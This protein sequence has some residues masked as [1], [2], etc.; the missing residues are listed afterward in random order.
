M[1]MVG[2]KLIS[3][4]RWRRLFLLL[5]L[6]LL[7]VPATRATHI[8]GGEMELQY[9][10]G[11]TYTL[12][13]NLYFDAINGSP[14]ALDQQ[15]RA[16][17]FAKATNQRMQD[18]MLPLVS[19]TFVNYT[20]PACAR[21]SL[22]TRKL[23]YSRDVTLDASQYT[24]AGGYYAA[25][26]RCC[27]NNGISN[28]T[29]SLTSGQTFYLEFPAVVRNGQPFRDSTPRI[30][31][32]LGDYAC[33]NE[34]FY[35]DFGGQDS[36]GDSLVYSMITPLTAPQGT[37]ALTQAGPYAL[38]NWV[39]GLSEQQQIPGTPT[40]GIDARTGRLTIRPSQV[41]LF[42]FGIRCEEYRQGVKIGET[43]R[44]FQLFV[45]DCTPNTRPSAQVYTGSST[46]AYRPGRDTLRI[47]PGQNPCVRVRFTDTDP[48]SRLTLSVRPVN[49]SGPVPTVAGTA[50]GLVRGAGLADTLQGTVCFSPCLDSKGQVWLL[51]VLVAD[52]GCSL[53]KLDTVRLAFTARPAPNAAPT[54]I[55]SF[56]ATDPAAAVLVKVPLGSVYTAQLRATDA[57]RNPLV[58]S[59][60]PQN[61]D[62]TAA[63]MEFSA[64]NGAGQATGT[65]RWLPTCEAAQLGDEL[66][67]QFQLRETADCPTAP[68]LV[69]VR[70][71][72]GPPVDTVAFSP[73]NIITPNGDDKNDAFTIPSLPPDYC[74]ARF[75]GIKIYSRWGREVFQSA[76]RTFRWGGAG[77]AGTYYYL[78]TYSNGR[79]YK[80]WV[81]VLQ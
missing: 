16:A 75:A 66:T 3:G 6:W 59:A 49:F 80:G 52:N 9:K 50:T 76:E 62:L 55:T 72:V 39:A 13:L 37:Q 70:F 14:N 34:L 28:I 21:S 43:R 20:N 36:D 29:N 48:N 17:I 58:L 30:F 11:S 68:R 78:I 65:F 63:G 5:V 64:Q 27:R 67:V 81:E 1:E 56:P 31:P 61:F 33:L 71:V 19:N 79:R 73:P 74:D 42:V 60:T 41:G 25:A 38:V 18:L 57:D 2:V 54:L 10:S 12:V 15:I 40:I 32:P 35:Y 4:R 22:S 69:P 51:D 77:A 23:V 26:E 47:A 53:P 7:L 45:L 46:R 44:D 8:V 24:A